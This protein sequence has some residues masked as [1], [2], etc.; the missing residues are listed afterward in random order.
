[1]LTVFATAKLLREVLE[2]LGQPGIVGEILAGVLIGPHVLNWIH[3]NDFLTGLSELG[4][5]FLLFRIGLEVRPSDL[6][7]VGARA[8][9]V[10]GSG[11]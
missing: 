10:A 1:M 7:R 9:A 6:L 11:V 4:V 8:V 3:P 5:I 2:R